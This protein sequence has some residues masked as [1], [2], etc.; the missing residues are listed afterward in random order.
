MTNANQISAGTAVL[1]IAIV[2]GA[3]AALFAA[4][5]WA[6]DAGYITLG[7]DSKGVIAVLGGMFIALALLFA[8][9]QSLRDLG[10]K[11]PKRWWTVPFWMVGIFGAYVV[12]QALAPVLVSSFID[13]P[14]PDLTRH[15]NL[16]QNLPA[17]L[18]MAAILPFTASI[19]EEI[20]YRGFLMNRLSNIFGV[21]VI[22]TILTILIQGMIF[23]SVHFQWGLGGM[24]VTTIMGMIWGLGYV[25]CGRNLW[26]VILAHSFGHILFVTQLYFIEGAP[27]G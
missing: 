14:E 15:N 8:R 6:R 20:I 25:L 1:D 18:L 19:P 7:E 10:F 22:G 4:E 27:A 17:A 23:G 2:M 26:I 21:G 9:G 5:V 16:Y 13:L 3:S 12:A 11:R 24:I